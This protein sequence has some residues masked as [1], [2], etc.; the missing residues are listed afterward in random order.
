MARAALVSC[1]RN[2]GPG[3]L[4]WVAY[5]LTIGFDH[6]AVA[7]NDCTDGSDQMLDRLAQIAPLSHHPHIPAPGQ[8]PQ[9]SGIATIFATLTS[10][11]MDWVLHIDADE[12]LCVGLGDGSVRDLLAAAGHGDV[13]ALAWRNF[14]AHPDPGW[15]HGHVLPEIIWGQDDTDLRGIAFKSMFRRADFAHANDHMPRAARNPAPLVVNAQGDDLHNF[16]VLDDSRVYRRYSPPELALRRA[17][18]CINHYAIKS[19]RLFSL[20][21]ARGDGQALDTGK[22]RPDSFW[23]RAANR[24]ETLQTRILRHWPATERHLR[25]LRR[26]PVLRALERDCRAYHDALLRSHA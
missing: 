17:A 15:A 3:L 22:Y 5:H 23:Y 13:I 21:G 1:M 12:F 14:G 10:A 8:A 20:R 11:Q 25:R 19:D 16:Q 9:D 4:E 7:T 6:V 24:R 2:E 18:A 26:D